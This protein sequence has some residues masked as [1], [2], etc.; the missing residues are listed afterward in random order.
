[1]IS[2]FGFILVL[3]LIFLAGC[4]KKDLELKS[5][6][7]RQQDE[8]VSSDDLSFYYVEVKKKCTWMTG[9]PSSND[10]PIPFICNA[11]F[12]KD[13]ECSEKKDGTSLPLEE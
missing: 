12:K 10:G 6:E 11:P 4:E 1:M 2:T 9:V 5:I 8:I 7:H 13:C 3:G